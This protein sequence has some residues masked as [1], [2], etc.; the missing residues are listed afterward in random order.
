MNPKSRGGRIV[1]EMLLNCIWNFV[2]KHYPFI[3]DIS[4]A[5]KTEGFIM[6]SRFK[7]EIKRSALG[8]AGSMK[9]FVTGFR[10]AHT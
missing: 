2:G 6:F 5:S 9:D 3:G 4:N 1:G 7:T 8:H 10:C